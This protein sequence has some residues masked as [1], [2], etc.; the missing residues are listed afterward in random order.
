[1]RSVP[2]RFSVSCGGGLAVEGLGGCTPD[3]WGPCAV[4]GGATGSVRVPFGIW[5]NNG[6]PVGMTTKCRL[7]G[8]CRGYSEFFF[9]HFGYC[10]KNFA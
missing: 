9:A 5:I 1:M 4:N 7:R 2:N 10:R 8:N 3:G 6:T